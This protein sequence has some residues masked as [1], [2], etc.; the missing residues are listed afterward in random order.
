MTFGRFTVI[1]L[2]AMYTLSG[3][4]L[5]DL[6]QL[7]L[8]NQVKDIHGQFWN[9]RQLRFKGL[10]VQNPKIGA[11]SKYCEL[12]LYAFVLVVSQKGVVNGLEENGAFALW[13]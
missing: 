12:M 7:T 9:R 8:H 3:Y 13:Q 4:S 11:L 2:G 10:V 6:P 1:V 5:K